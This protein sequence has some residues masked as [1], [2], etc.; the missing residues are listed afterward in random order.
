MT[1]PNP[2]GEG[3]QRAMQQAL[4][5]GGFTV[6]D[7]GHVNAHGTST[8]AND[9]TEA[10]AL[11]ALA[12]DELGRKIPITSVKNRRGR[13]GFASAVEAVVT[14]LSVANRCVRPYKFAS[15]TPECP[16]NVVSESLQ[17]YPQKV[18]LSNS[19]GFGGHNAVLAISP[20]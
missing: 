18:A 17:N 4:D 2:T 6:A 5:E 3:I 8:H 14:A 10:A 12:G 7:L 20:F 9:A 15:P 11:I 19:L 1:A 16:V 13:A